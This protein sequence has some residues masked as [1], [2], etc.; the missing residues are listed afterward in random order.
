MLNVCYTLTIVIF[1]MTAIL[2]PIYFIRM[3]TPEQSA[4]KKNFECGFSL[5]WSPRTPFSTRFF[6]LSVVF[7]VF[8]VELILLFPLIS[9][10]N[11]LSSNPPYLLI[12]I[13]SA[14]LLGVFF[15]WKEG[16]F[17]WMK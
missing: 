2:L 14:L 11:S 8:D 9:S 10:S 6:L 15:E 16:T 4:K 13:F 17:D 5:F 3:N 7:L 12:F 1:L